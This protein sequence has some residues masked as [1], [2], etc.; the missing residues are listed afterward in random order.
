[1][2]RLCRILGLA[3]LAATAL[4]LRA[5][6]VVSIAKSA[7]RA[8]T[9]EH[10][11]IAENLLA[12]RGFAIRFLGVE[13]PTSQQ[14][15]LYPA[16]LAACYW[17]FGTGS[18]QAL[19]AMQGLQ[20]FAGAGLAL[21]VVW[22]AWSL[23]PDRTTVGWA[24]GWGAAVYPTHVYMVTHIQVAVWAALCLTLLVALAASPTGRSSWRKAAAVGVVAGVLLLIEPILALSLPLVAWM[25]WCSDLGQ[26][27]ATGGRRSL[28]K[29]S[30]PGG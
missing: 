15:P 30:L 29:L 12:G 22:L 24:A 11:E 27:P 21:A 3:L 20:C 25:F 14:A 19:L 13:G 7:P 18:P 23:V 10:G 5:A 9:Y 28:E 16:L 17:S 26:H 2:P 4:G 8:V 1:M 6:V